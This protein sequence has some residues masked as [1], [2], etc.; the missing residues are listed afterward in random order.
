MD[1]SQCF[2]VSRKLPRLVCFGLIAF[3]ANSAVAVGPYYVSQ[4][5]VF[6]PL[7]GCRLVD[8]RADTDGND[9]KFPAA[10]TRDYLVWDDEFDATDLSP[11]GGSADGC[12]VSQCATAI[13]A[14]I[15]VASPPVSS[16]YAR[17]WNAGDPE[18]TATVLAWMAGVQTTNSVN[19]PICSRSTNAGGRDACSADISFH[20][21]GAA[22]HFIIDVTGYYINPAHE[23]GGPELDS[24]GAPD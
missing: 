12:G 8:T 19:I 5:S 13:H 23:Q 15:S 20:N 1:I 22:T 4:P 3:S 9:V 17:I 6:V 16:G 2:S 11:Q 24:C 18:P 21:Y 10:S 7:T 14:S